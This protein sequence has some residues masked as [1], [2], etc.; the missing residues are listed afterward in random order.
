MKEKFS[1]YKMD[2]KTKSQAEL[3]IYGI[4]I[5]SVTIFAAIASRMS[6]PINND[7]TETYNYKINI[8]LNDSL[9]NYYGIKT[10]EEITINKVV[11]EITTSYSYKNDKYYRH[12]NDVYVLTN[13]EEIY[14]IVEFSYLSLETI[15]NYLE[16]SV[17][18]ENGNIVYL[19]DIILGYSK[20][21]YITI[22]KEE[23]N[24]NIDYTSLMKLFDNSVEKLTIEI[25]IE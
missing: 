22:E 17:L 23:K 3:L 4:F 19:K 20:E 1:K 15:N 24:Y 2:S 14:D 9:Y 7:D 12:E 8:N 5:I 6:G 16:L 25:I 11:N 21:E 18:T 10:S 13:E